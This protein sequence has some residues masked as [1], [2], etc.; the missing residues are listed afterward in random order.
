MSDMPT[1]IE[2]GKNNDNGWG[3]NAWG[4]GAGAFIGSMFGNGGFGGWGGYRN[5][6]Q[7]GADVALQTGLQN[8]SDQ[9][10][11]NGLTSLQGD[12]GIQQAVSNAAAGVTNGIYQ[13]ALSNLQGQNGIQMQVANTGA[14]LANGQSQQTISNLQGQNAQNVNTLQGF[15]G[16]GQQLCCLGG[17]LSQEI[18]QTGDLINAS[19]QNGTVQGLRNTQQISD[20]LCQTNQNILNQ[21]YET[22]LLGQNLASQ[23]QNQHA[24]LKATIIEQGCQDREVMREIANQQVRDKLAEAQAKIVQLETQN[25]V[26]Q[27][28]SQ[29]TLYLINQLKPAAAAAAGA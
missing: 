12:N 18:D 13:N 24:D 17:K 10:H 7:V 3:G 4:A 19:I 27:S 23:L 15:A 26:N 20:R 28:N 22:R 8:L 16:V 25:Y 5:A 14:A 6:G 1:I 9:V 21:G 29:Q 11:N 2:T